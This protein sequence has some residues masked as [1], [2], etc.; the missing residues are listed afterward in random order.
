MQSN[1]MYGFKP[2]RFPAPSI[3]LCYKKGAITAK[4]T[5]RGW[6]DCVITGAIVPP[7]TPELLY[8]MKVIWCDKTQFN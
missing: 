2:N 5:Q 1:L 8:V 4:E 7:N 6:W 3:V